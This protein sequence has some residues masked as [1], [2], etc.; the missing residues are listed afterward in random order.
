M[1]RGSTAK[2]VRVRRWLVLPLVFIAGSGWLR[3]ATPVEILGALP[4][5]EEVAIS[6]DGTE[7]A[8]VHTKGDVRQIVVLMLDTGQVRVSTDVGRSKLRRLIWA[9]KDHLLALQSTATQPM[10]LVSGFG[11]WATLWVIDLPAKKA[12]NPLDGLISGLSTNMNVVFGKPEVRTVDGETRLYL[13]GIGMPGASRDE[14]VGGRLLPALIRVDLAH[15]GSH[16]IAMG[17]AD[18]RD[19]IIDGAGSVVAEER[20]NVSTERW[21][22]FPTTQ[23][24]ANPLA[25]GQAAIDV[26]FLGGITLDGSGLWVRTKEE[27]GWEWCQLS[28]E[29]GELKPVSEE[30]RYADGLMTE[31]LTGRVLAGGSSG[32]LR[33]IDRR[34]QQVWQAVAGAFPKLRIDLVSADDDFNKLVVRVEDGPHG[35][36]Y[37]LA[38]LI[39]HQTKSLGLAYDGLSQ[40]ATVRP[41]HYQAQDGLDIAGFLTLPPGREA[42]QLPLVVLPHRGPAVSDDGDF[43]WWAQALAAQGY[44]VLQPNYRGSSSSDALLT[45][46]FGQWGR[47]MQTDLSDGV[48]TLAAQ[49]LIDPAR[50]CIVGAGYGGYAALA[51][52]TLQSGIYRCAVDVAGISDLRHFLDWLHDHHSALAD[53]YLD[54]FLG[55]NGPYDAQIDALSPLKHLPKQPVPTLVIHGRDDTVVPFEQSQ[56]FVDAL[57]HQGTPVTLTE[58][59]QEDHWLSRSATRLQMLQATVDFLQANN[60]P[61]GGAPVPH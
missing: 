29:G 4:A 8:F 59:K 2:V 53:R 7:L 13:I 49:G 25:A 50:V 19:W 45:A 56:M 21:A 42:H 23:A 31:R 47:K 32:R 39:S 57:R 1:T 15:L 14:T 24:A 51:G 48:A 33:F 60:P 44:A 40:A 22:I 52:V 12:V 9:D 30:Y 27:Q 10:G 28:F 36:V 3:A 17:T 54:R 35:P 20:Y 37:A 43:D 58:L 41:I 46:G 11:E 61:D 6:P 26:P 16:L 5:T 34:R 18:T 55:I 38:D